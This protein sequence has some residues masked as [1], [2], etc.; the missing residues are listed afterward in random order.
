LP[1][2]PVDETYACQPATEYE[3]TKLQGE[4][5]ILERSSEL[6]IPAVVLRPTFT[7]GPG[8]P[9]KIA[10]FRAVK[11]RRYA[12]IGNGQ[13]LLHPVFID[14]LIAGVFLALERARVGEIYIIGGERP[15]SKQE[16]VFSIAD[17]LG[18]TR[19]GLKIPRWF[20]G[21]AAPLL[22]L[23][24]RCF[25]F[26]PILTRSRIMM[27]A[28]NFGYSIEKARR[29]L[30]YAPQTGLDEG[31]SRTIQHYEDHRLL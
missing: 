9:H 5:L 20:A 1:G 27:M 23:A 15:V 30:G 28:D 4:Q 14:D 22:E 2:G 26:E 29:E 16:L 12:F 21:L 7:Y 19:P 3:R 24:G 10:L 8:D 17:G 11:K 13:S 18:V 25:G 6:G 31:I